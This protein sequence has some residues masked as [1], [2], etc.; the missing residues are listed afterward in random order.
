[1]KS[2]SEIHVKSHEMTKHPFGINISEGFEN[3]S[4]TLEVTKTKEK[5]T[6]TY[7][8]FD[9]DFRFINLKAIRFRCVHSSKN[10]H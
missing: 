3:K 6:S 9:G 7:L 5:F 8:C 1:M 2:S 4:D 10:L